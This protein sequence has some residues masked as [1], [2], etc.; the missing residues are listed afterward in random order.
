MKAFSRTVVD[1]FGVEYLCAP[2]LDDLQRIEKKFRMVGFPGCAGAVDCAGRCWKN[3]PKALQESLCGKGSKPV[4]RVEVICDLDLWIWSFQ[5]RLPGVLND[6]NI[7]SV[8][9]HFAK[10]LAGWFPPVAPHY[11]VSG[12]NVRWFYYLADGIFPPW[13]VFCGKI[14]DSELDKEDVFVKAREGVRKCV[15]RVFGVLF[16]QFKILFVSSCSIMADPD[17]I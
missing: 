13:K 8:S 11:V 15:E 1:V 14:D 5:F 2:T 7:L 17:S 10:V 12:E 16:T 3:A 4:L 6:L 9:E